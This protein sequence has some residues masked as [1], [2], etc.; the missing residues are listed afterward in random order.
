[1]SA[2]GSLF[3]KNGRAI[4]RG[5]NNQQ[6][7]TEGN[8]GGGFSTH[9]IQPASP[10]QEPPQ[11]SQ[12]VKIFFSRPTLRNVTVKEEGGKEEEEEKVNYLPIVMGS[13]TWLAS[14]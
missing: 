5:A 3:A 1:M 10:L 7:V 8:I 14:Y 6:V 11:G 12:M 9:S 13:V 4:W 2:G